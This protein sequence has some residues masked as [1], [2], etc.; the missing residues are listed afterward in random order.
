VLV[1][2]VSIGDVVKHQMSRLEFERDQLDSYV[3]QG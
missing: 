3:A 1:G 2:I